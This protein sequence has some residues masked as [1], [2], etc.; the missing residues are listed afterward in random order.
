M[1][2]FSDP[3]EGSIAPGSEL[4]QHKMSTFSVF[5]MI[6]C[7]VA[8]GYFGMEDMVS[9][10]GPGLTILIL[11]VF[12][13]F[14]SIPQAL[15]AS[16]L[17]SAMPVEGGYYKW[18]QRAFG[19]FWGFQVGWWRTISCYVDTTLYIILAVAYIDAFIPLGTVGSFLAKLAIVAIFTVI[20][21]L[22]IQEV[23]RITTILMVFV[24][25]TLVVFI[26]FG[27]ANWEFSPVVPF[28]PAGQ[29]VISSLGF[30]IAFCIWVYSGYESMGTMAGEL[31]NPQ[32]I[33]KATLMTIPL[34]TAV[35]ILPIIFGLASYGEYETWSVDNGISFVTIIA[36]YGMP[37]LTFVFML[38]AIACNVS[39]Y[40]SYLASG[41][42][43]FFVLAEDRL[44]PL[45]L[46]KVNKKFGTPHLA[47]ISM[48]VVNLFLSQF[49]FATLV[50]VDVIL[51]MFAYLIWFLAA[52]ALRMKEPDMK[53]PFRIPFG[54]KGV[55]AMTV[56]PAIICV[57]ALFTN[58]INYLIGGSIALASGPVMYVIFKK[59]YGGIDNNKTLTSTQKKGV[60]FLSILIAVC[61]VI[62]FVMYNNERTQANESFGALMGSGSTS[63]NY[64]SLGSSYVIPEDS[65]ALDL[66]DKNIEN[67]DT[68]IWYYNGDLTADVY[69]Y[70]E[71]ADEKAFAQTKFGVYQRLSGLGF[72]Q[73]DIYSDDFA[74]VAYDGDEYASA[75]D[76]LDFL[77]E[78]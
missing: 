1:S 12:P 57:T 20:N 28:V 37:G 75:Q 24:L 22:G 7:L 50:V 21:I 53:R 68:R 19:E 73:I 76:V 40:N 29:P 14:W 47:I 56:V 65:F 42:R 15:I 46:S 71:F 5:L 6:F 9:G 78:G 32:V 49:G 55:I 34:V 74:F 11:I 66:T 2:N 30:G 36:S 63:A 18:V 60:A 23:A 10:T 16:E 38:G 61:L 54:T 31:K 59:V 3:P 33:P 58:G 41:S 52:I 13:F 72:S 25:A 27:A 39:L 67:A 17:G 26:Y 77:A 62:G 45:S 69:L 35:Y 8:G 44:S 43:G 70:D 64:E 51:F 48:A 4:K